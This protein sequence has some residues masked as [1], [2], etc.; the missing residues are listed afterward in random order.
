MIVLAS[1]A[2]LVAAA[3]TI[4]VFLANGMSDSPSMPFQGNGLIIG[5]WGLTAVL[6]LAWWVG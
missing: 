6:W 3:V 4:V 2:T 5:T 1:L